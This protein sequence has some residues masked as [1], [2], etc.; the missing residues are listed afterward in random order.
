MEFTYKNFGFYNIDTNYLKYLYETDNEVQFDENQNYDHKPFVGIL[1]TMEKYTYFIPLTSRKR[2]HAHWNNVSNDHILIYEIIDK[3]KQN[4]NDIIKPYSNTHVI[5]ILAAL[6][7]KKMVPVPDNCYSM[8]NFEAETDQRYR[9]LLEK[10]FSF[11]DS[12]KS[13]ILERSKRTYTYQKQTKIVLP[14]HC[15]YSL[16]ESA[17]DKYIDS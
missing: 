16:L 10:E 11:C 15:N 9:N 3:E 8:I 5:R 1:V 17:C 12:I 7:I 6:E 2:K 13:N 14:Y 4:Y